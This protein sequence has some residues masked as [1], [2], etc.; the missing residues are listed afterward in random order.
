[1]VPVAPEMEG[2]ATIVLH[3]GE[4]VSR[5]AAD[6]LV[7]PPPFRNATVIE[8]MT[9]PIFDRNEFDSLG[10]RVPGMTMDGTGQRQDPTDRGPVCDGHV[11]GNSRSRRTCRRTW[12][13]RRQVEPWRWRR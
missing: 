2:A 9:P 7:R 5:M 11:S 1:M 4:V 6:R 8:G 10:R 13:Q 12:R 3:N